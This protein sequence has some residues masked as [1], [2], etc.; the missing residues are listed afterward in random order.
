MNI[1]AF[2]RDRAILLNK[3]L[4]SGNSGAIV[5]RGFSPCRGDFD[6]EKSLSG[7]MV[8]VKFSGKLKA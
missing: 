7:R 3:R 2:A 5:Y 4:L 1:E 6:F 8:V